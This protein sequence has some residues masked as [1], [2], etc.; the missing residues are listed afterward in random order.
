MPRYFP[1]IAARD[2]WQL[3]RYSGQ[4]ETGEEV[5]SRQRLGAPQAGVRPRTSGFTLPSARLQR[6]AGS[7]AMLR[8]A[9]K[10]FIINIINQLVEKMTVVTF[11][12]IFS[13]PP[14]D[15]SSNWFLRLFTGASPAQL[16][17]PRSCRPAIA[18][19]E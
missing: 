15:E 2:Q 8:I 16:H 4:G 13:Q 14:C 6:I 10:L 17:D 3:P 12:T 1:A 18:G 9:Y 7:G 11:S 5:A 19:S